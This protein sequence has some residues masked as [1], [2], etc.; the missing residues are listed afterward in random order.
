MLVTSVANDAG[1]P[2][3]APYSS[4]GGK[5][6]VQ[7]AGSAWAN[8]SGKIRVNL[9]LDGSAIATASV[10]TNEPISHKA[11]VPVTV[12]AHPTRG[13]HTFSV[14]AANG[15]TNIDFNDFFTITVTES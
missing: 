7:F 14:A 9:L 4:H 2:V 3:N 1:F 15:N 10:F 11:L 13:Q 8:A 12:Q 6:D 5:L